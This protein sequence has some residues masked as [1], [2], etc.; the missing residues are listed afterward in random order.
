MEH[1]PCQIIGL[2]RGVETGHDLPRLAEL[3]WHGEEDGFGFGRSD[4]PVRD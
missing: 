4:R 1:I 3:R 2:G